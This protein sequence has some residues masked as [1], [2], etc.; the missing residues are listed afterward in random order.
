[1]NF[2]IKKTSNLGKAIRSL[3]ERYENVYNSARKFRLGKH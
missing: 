1:M 3:G 2:L